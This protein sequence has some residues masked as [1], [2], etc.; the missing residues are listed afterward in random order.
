MWDIIVHSVFN[1]YYWILIG[2]HV[3]VLSLITGKLRKAVLYF[4]LFSIT[5][6]ICWGILYLAHEHWDIVGKILIG[7][8]LCIGVIVLYIIAR[9][10]RKAVMYLVL[11]VP[12][13]FICWGLYYFCHEYWYLASRMLILLIF[14]IGCWLGAIFGIGGI[15]K[16][17][18]W[19]SGNKNYWGQDS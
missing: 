8:L 18:S 12:A 2:F 4:V 6:L 19:L 7:L 9:N 17:I 1:P 10:S 15:A 14:C 5:A 11:G 16:S 3:I 13:F